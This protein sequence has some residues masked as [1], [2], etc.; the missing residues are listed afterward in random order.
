MAVSYR[1]T[2]AESRPQRRAKRFLERMAAIPKKVKRRLNAANEKS[3][4][5]LAA[6]MVR[7]AP[8]D[9]R[10]LVASIRYF[11]VRG[12]A[13]ADVAW[14]VTAG[15]NDAFYARMVEFGT[16]RHIIKARKGGMLNI[17]GRLVSQ[18]DHPGARAKPFMRP[19]FAAK[20]GEALQE[21]KDALVALVSV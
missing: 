19:A 12:G 8:K 10:D 17:N 18:V 13:G 14:R 15:D 2:D 7:L 3:A 16:Q 1:I 4:E 20:E 9:E 5:E 21:I 6:L 11:E